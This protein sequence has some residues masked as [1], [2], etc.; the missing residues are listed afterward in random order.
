MTPAPSDG[1]SHSRSHSTHASPWVGPGSSLPPQG[2][3]PSD[4]WAPSSSMPAQPGFIPPK[5][6]SHAPPGVT[7]GG[8]GTP[9]PSNVNVEFMG[10][11]LNFVPMPFAGSTSLPAGGGGGMGG[12]MGGGYPGM[13]SFQAPMSSPWSTPGMAP[14]MG[15]G[16]M[17]GGNGW[18]GWWY[19]YGDIVYGSWYGY[20]WDGWKYGSLKIQ[21]GYNK[22]GDG[23]AKILPWASRQRYTPENDGGIPKRNTAIA[24]LISPSPYSFGP[25]ATSSNLSSI[26]RMLAPF[27]SPT[28]RRAE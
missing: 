7:P 1:R 4:Q 15:M 17:G 13:T 16:G 2:Y 14:G 11:Y 21:F 20:G 19:G 3:H 26:V 22:R 28:A 25:F 12:G 24:F 6:R 5:T 18:Y 27:R 9:L 8:G 23:E 10:G